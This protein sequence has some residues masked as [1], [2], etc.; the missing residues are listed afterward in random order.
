M[1][2]L[3]EFYPSYEVRC[4]LRMS[5][6]PYKA[7]FC[8]YPHVESTGE[9]PQVQDGGALVGNDRALH[10]VRDLTKLDTT[11]SASERAYSLGL[12]A[13]V[14]STLKGVERWSL[15]QGPKGGRRAADCIHRVTPAPLSWLVASGL[16]SS[17]MERLALCGLVEGGWVK[18]RAVE[19]YKALDT[20]LAANG[21]PFFFGS[22]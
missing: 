5:S 4:L 3:S 2:L 21:G 1:L 20:V 11:L 13:L 15:H 9:L 16:R 18:E 12:L 6:T 10:Y 7:V 19:T 8:R 14:Q 17:N 22:R